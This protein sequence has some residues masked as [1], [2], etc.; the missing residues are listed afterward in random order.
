MTSLEINGYCFYKRQSQMSY[1]LKQW[2][3]SKC[4]SVYMFY[5]NPSD[6]KVSA[7]DNCRAI[8]WTCH[9]K[10]LRIVSGNTFNFTVAWIT[11][12]PETG[13]LERIF[14]MTRSGSYY[15]DIK[16]VK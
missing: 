14:W 4:N 15:A 10:S 2:A 13:E 7:M 1:R 5:K 8:C 12:N 6:N 11:E 9:G 3:L 16:G